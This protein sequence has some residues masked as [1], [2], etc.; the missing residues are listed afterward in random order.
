MFFWR[1]A[2]KEN[3]TFLEGIFE[4]LQSIV[5]KDVQ[6]GG[7]AMGNKDFVGIFPCN[8]YADSLA[9]GDGCHMDGI[10]IVVIEHKNIVIA[11]AGHG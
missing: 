5:V 7:M 2:L 9:I 11:A 8:A 1:H 3:V 4:I 6:F 10:C